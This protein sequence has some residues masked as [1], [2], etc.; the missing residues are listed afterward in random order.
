MIEKHPILGY[1]AFLLVGFVGLALCT[2]MGLAE[3]GVSWHMGIDLKFGCITGIVVLSLLY[4]H[5]TG[6][7]TVLHP[8]VYLFRMACTAF[9]WVVGLPFRPLKALLHHRG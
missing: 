5:F 2:E 8:A 1:T 9:A 7:R 6:L 3:A 4:E